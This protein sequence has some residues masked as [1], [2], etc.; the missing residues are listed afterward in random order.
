MSTNEH[1]NR[2]VPLVHEPRLWACRQEG[3][4]LWSS[5]MLSQHSDVVYTFHHAFSETLTRRLRCFSINVGIQQRLRLYRRSR[6][7]RG[8]AGLPW[9][10]FLHGTWGCSHPSLSR[11]TFD[12]V[13]KSSPCS[14]RCAYAR[15]VA[16]FTNA[17]PCQVVINAVKW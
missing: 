14:Q 17:L 13:V 7:L 4:S 9:R 12:E 1:K 3:G 2:G 5:C 6:H 15:A 8:W 16:C 10:K 11:G